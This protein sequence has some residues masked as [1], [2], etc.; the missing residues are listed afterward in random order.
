MPSA[1]TSSIAWG[2]TIFGLDQQDLYVEELNPSDPLE[3]RTESGWARMT[4]RRED[5]HIKGAPSRAIDLKFT[6]HGPVLWQD[7]TRALALR[8]V[9]SEPGTAGYL[10]SLAS[11]GPGIGASSRRR[12]PRWKVPSENLVY[13]DRAGNIG[14]HSAGLAPVRSWTGLLPVPGAGHYEWKGFL[15]ASLLPH[16]F[17]PAEGFVA[18]ANHK[19]IPEDY[20][21]PVGF[22]WTPPYRYERIR[23]VIESH[24]RSGHKLTIADMEALQNDVVSLPARDLQSLVRATVLRAKPELAAFLKWDAAVTRESSAA[25][26]YEVWMRQIER[27]LAVRFSAK[28]SAHYEDLTPSALLT[29]L[30][31]PHEELFGANPVATRDALLEDALA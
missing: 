3:Y 26:L 27:A 29:V 31:D 15:A 10:A 6:R 11:I 24:V 30:S 8:W 17:N 19:M 9:G 13:A 14:E 22:E 12:C 23:E 20:P 25:A 18:T 16:T 1:T 5:F 2:F 7:G 21:Y 28:D 4:L